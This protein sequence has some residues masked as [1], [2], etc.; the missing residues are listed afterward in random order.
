MN[1]T[2]FSLLF[3]EVDNP[4][5]LLSALAGIA[6]SRN[7]PE[8][9]FYSVLHDLSLKRNNYEGYQQNPEGFITACIKN[10]CSDYFKKEGKTTS[11]D[12]K[13]IVET[14]TEPDFDT[15]N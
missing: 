1:T 10:A 9:E 12:E 4:S 2:D 6:H 11:F 5:K 14:Y 15:K 3:P 13:L 8:H 7:L